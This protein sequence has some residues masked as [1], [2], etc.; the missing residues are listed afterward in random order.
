[1]VYLEKDQLAQAEYLFA[2]SANGLHLLFDNDTIKRVMSRPADKDHFS[3]ENSQKVQKILSEFISK[4]GLK[5]KKA[6]LQ[7]LDLENHD[8][9]VR[10]YFNIVENSIF[11]KGS[12]LKH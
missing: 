11:E 1:M 7:T 12:K 9:L 8:L 10:A 3:F 5:E 6:F 2:Q 4:P